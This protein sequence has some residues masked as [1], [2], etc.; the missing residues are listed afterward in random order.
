MRLWHKDLIDVLPNE[1]LLNQWHDICR[2]SISLATQNTPNDIL[3]NRLLEYPIDHFFT[4]TEM[5]V[6]PEINKRGY[7][8]DNAYW[9]NFVDGVN[10]FSGK[11]VYNVIGFDQLFQG[12][13][14]TR[15]LQQCLLNLE[16]IYDCNGIELKE[17]FA[18]VNKVKGMSE[19]CQETFD[20]LFT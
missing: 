3:V 7:Q 20:N 18:I 17:W 16:E 2:I 6:V 1:L 11:Q 19:L 10:K 5:L 9:S 8:L 15:Y 13:H 4:Y 12:W 14:S